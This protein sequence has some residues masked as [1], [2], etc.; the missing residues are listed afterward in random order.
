M[1]LKMTFNIHL[2]I[3]QMNIDAEDVIRERAYGVVDM[4]LPSKTLWAKYNIGAKP[5]MKQTEENWNEA[6]E[7]WYGDYFAFGEIKPKE[8]Y[9]FDTYKFGINKKAYK[10]SDYLSKYYDV[11][12]S[13]NKLDLYD[14]AT[15]MNTNGVFVMPTQEQYEEL[16]KHCTIEHVQ[17]Y[18]NIGGLHGRLFTSKINGKQLFFPEAGIK[19]DRNSDEGY[20]R[21]ITYEN[22]YNNEDNICFYWSCS[23]S[24]GG[25]D[26]YGTEALHIC[27]NNYG[28]DYKFVTSMDRTMGLPIRGVLRK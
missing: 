5:I 25:T 8:K 10:H 15:Y 23:L 17:H 1:I 22:I 3:N 2:I 26:T 27:T 6:P 14:D 13:P 4:G 20:G 12:K 11:F 9:N 21:S 16:L 19:S 28:D 24:S 18:N 7:S